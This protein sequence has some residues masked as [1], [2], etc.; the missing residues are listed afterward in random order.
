VEGPGHGPKR[1]RR[2]GPSLKP[3]IKLAPRRHAYYVA[4]QQLWTPKGK[5]MTIRPRRSALYMPGSNAR[6]LEKARSLPADVVIFDLEDAVA[7]E[8][9]SMAREQAAAAIRAGGYGDREIVLRVNSLAT[10]WGRDDIAA[11]AQAGAHAILVPKV[12]TPGDV[13][14]AAAELRKAGAADSTRVW[15]MM[16]TPMAILNADSI[17]RVARDPASRLDALVMGTNDLAKETRARITQGRPALVAWL[18]ICVAAARS[19]GADILDGVYGDIADIAG[20]RAECE[21]GRDMGMDGKTLIHPSQIPSCNETFTPDPRELEWA[22]KLV[23]AF[24][25]PENAAKGAIAL[26]GRM[27]ERL[28]ADIARRNLDIAEAIARKAN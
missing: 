22:R 20:F 24:E 21:Q 15:I 2:G 14:M 12:S 23:A 27:V 10:E 7:P 4:L 25:A 28:H 13:T 1:T 18:A 17:A 16:E 11:A 3:N 5:R 9:K 19:Y 6:A 26:D 8:S